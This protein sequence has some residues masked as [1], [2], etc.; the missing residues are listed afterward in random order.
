[1]FGALPSTMAGPG[2]LESLTGRAG[3]QV[4]PSTR[5]RGPNCCR[6][7]KT[8]RGIPTVFY[9]IKI[10]KILLAVRKREEKSKPK[11]S[12]KLFKKN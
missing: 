12:S 7:E 11:F 6:R 1:M 4:R 9:C 8:R 2:S 10:S 5:L 3:R